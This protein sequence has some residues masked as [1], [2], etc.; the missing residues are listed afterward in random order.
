MT[1][2]NVSQK[3]ESDDT[4]ME[5]S[6]VVCVFVCVCVCVCLFVSVC[7]CVCVCLLDSLSVHPSHAFIASEIGPKC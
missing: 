2:K 6:Y 7:V 4:K 3:I 5:V 1:K